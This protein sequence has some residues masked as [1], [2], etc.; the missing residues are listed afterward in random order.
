MTNSRL[1]L[2]AVLALGLG[3]PVQAAALDEPSVAT[4]LPSQH[5]ANPASTRMN[6]SWRGPSTL[7]L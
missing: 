3:G 6:F 1:T 2:S 7:T 5:P 4:F